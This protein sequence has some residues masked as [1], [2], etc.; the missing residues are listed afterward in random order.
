MLAADTDFA[1]V[2]RNACAYVNIDGEWTN[3]PHS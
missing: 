1:G 3:R 2:V